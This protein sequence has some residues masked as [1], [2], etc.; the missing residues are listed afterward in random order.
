M[1]NIRGSQIRKGSLFGLGFK[2]QSMRAVASAA[3][4]LA[5]ATTGTVAVAT[6]T[7]PAAQAQ[8]TGGTSTYVPA[9]AGLAQRDT[10]L[11]YATISNN[12]SF[13]SSTGAVARLT[14]PHWFELVGGRDFSTNPSNPDAGKMVLRFRDPALYEAIDHIDIVGAN[15]SPTNIQT[16]MVKRH[17]AGSEWTA[18]LADF[19]SFGAIGAD[20][21][22]N[23]L[24]YLKNGATLASL[25]NNGEFF[26]DQYWI[27]NDGKIATEANSSTAI[28]VSQQ[29][30]S[31]MATKQPGTGVAS[32]LPTNAGASTRYDQA[33][34]VIYST[35]TIKPA[36]N[37]LQA[38]YS[39]SAIVEELIDPEIAPF[40]DSVTI[41]GSDQYGDIGAGRKEFPMNFDP[42]TGLAT[43]V[44]VPDLSWKTGQT[45]TNATYTSVRLNWD[46]IFQGTLGQSR[47][48][49][50]K[51]QLKND[52][53]NNMNETT[54][55]KLINATQSG[56]YF[57]VQSWIEADYLDKFV[58]GSAGYYDGGADPEIVPNS[59][60]HTY[61]AVDDLDKDGLL[62]Q[63]ER[64]IG[65]NSLNP[66]SDGDGVPDGVEKLIDGTDP[67]N[68][69][70]Y[71]P[72]KPET[73]KSS[74]AFNDL[75]SISGNVPWKSYENPLNPPDTLPVKNDNTST[76]TVYLVPESALTKDASG[77][78]TAVDTSG[79][80]AKSTLA[81]ASDIQNGNFSLT[82]TNQDPASGKY[83][84]VAVT[85]NGEFA[86]GSELTVARDNAALND[87]VAQDQTVKV[88]DT[89]KA[90][91]SI[92]N[93]ADLP[94]G[95]T[96]KFKDP[97]DTSTAG[98]KDAVV[99]VTY[100]DGS[101]EEVPVQVVVK[102][103]QADTYTPVVTPETVGADGKIDLTDNVTVP[104]YKEDPAFPGQPTFKDVT[105][106]G[107]IDLTKPGSYT[108]KVEVTYPDGSSEVVDVPVTVTDADVSVPQGQ[109]QTVAVDEKP[110]AEKSIANVA[111]LPAGTTFE[112]KTPV[113]TSTEG[114]KDAIVV[115][116]YP[117]GSKEEVPVTFTV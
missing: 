17:P 83:V 54:A 14:L 89:P 103:P 64:E 79:S 53:V 4:A 69:A 74:V 26:V 67:L 62:D 96:V 34:N 56:A 92:A 27:T 20:Y 30:P 90:E 40:V 117:D 15:G 113:D 94:A 73:S 102:T 50:V 87:P 93:L 110:S 9:D 101:S 75:G 86:V 57:D 58:L 60:T 23:A 107:A 49:T 16:T 32:W 33:Q 59:Y 1:A 12:P 98:T 108:G 84:L 115:V 42:A 45:I 21:Q 29:F 5:L 104:D 8:S 99:V 48:F 66:D 112:Y 61:L 88:G 65:T 41:Y 80:V 38:S 2:D 10:V 6:F 70:S 3:A 77:T 35:K 91:D 85:G 109:D 46:D 7:A 11:R 68:P 47:Y 82:Q 31:Q 25:P 105:P 116:T 22:S 51:Y 63:Y 55:A 39:W 106:A 19:A 97:V 111:D 76:L 43:T 81:K 13:D 36:Q 24:I 52:A 28:A 44:G 72:G 37:F 71:L 114:T 100:P 18:T 78:V 95:T